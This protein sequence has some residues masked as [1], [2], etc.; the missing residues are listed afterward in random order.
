MEDNWGWIVTTY[1]NDKS[2]DMMPR[3]A[4]MACSTAAEGERY[5][6][7]FAPKVNEVPLKRNIEIGLEEIA[8][9]VAWLERDLASVQRF[10]K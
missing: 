7:F 2:Y 5:R 10:F 6:T 1:S 9:R 8:S 4:A 3:Y